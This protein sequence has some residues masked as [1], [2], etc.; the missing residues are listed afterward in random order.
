MMHSELRSAAAWPYNNGKIP[1]E[2]Y[3]LSQTAIHWLANP[4][5]GP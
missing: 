1:N 2:Q 3:Y 4:D 5:G